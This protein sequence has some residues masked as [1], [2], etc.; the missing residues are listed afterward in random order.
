MT[1]LDVTAERVV[2]EAACCG[3]EA[4]GRSASG[5]RQAAQPDHPDR[6]KIHRVG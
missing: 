6:R 4:H 2:L 5:R 3:P 1:T